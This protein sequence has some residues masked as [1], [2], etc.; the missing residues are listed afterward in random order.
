MKAADFDFRVPE[1]LIPLRRRSCAAS[2][3]TKH[4]RLCSTAPGKAS[5]TTAS[6]CAGL[7]ETVKTMCE[8]PSLFRAL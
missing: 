7:T 8:R 2:V 5:Y 1:R 6:D 4:A 3:A